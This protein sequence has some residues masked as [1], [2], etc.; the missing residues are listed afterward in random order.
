VIEETNIRGLAEVMAALDTLAIKIEKNV[1]RGALRAGGKVFAADAKARA[2]FGQP[3]R[4]NIAKWGGYAGALRD[5]IR[6]TTK[7]RGKKVVAQVTAG[8]KSS[9]STADV[10]YARII[11]GGAKPHD[12]KPQTRKSLFFAGVCRDI[13]HHPGIRERKFLQKALF[14]SQRAATDAA[15]AYMRAR[16]T[17]AG[18]EVA[19]PGDD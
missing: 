3:S 7:V 12:I 9:K 8:G 19:D 6:V 1:M 17:K 10:F 18:I 11:E 4:E 2:P 16:L 15:V 14:G 5:S 13:V